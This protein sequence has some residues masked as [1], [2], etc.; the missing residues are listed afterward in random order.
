MADTLLTIV[1]NHRSPP[2]MPG[3]S[4]NLY[5]GYFENCYGEQWIFTY[6]RTTKEAVVTTGDVD[7]KPYPVGKGGTALLVMQVEESI[8][9]RACWHAATRERMPPPSFFKQDPHGP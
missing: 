5:V 8:W 1:S 4:D 6:D 9:L 2:E 7:W 3:N